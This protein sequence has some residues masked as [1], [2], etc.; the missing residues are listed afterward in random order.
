MRVGYAE[1]EAE[2]DAKVE[3]DPRR[4]GP[5]CIGGHARV[6]PTALRHREAQ[7]E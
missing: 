4:V 7:A 1:L 5:T 6:R 3:R 2:D